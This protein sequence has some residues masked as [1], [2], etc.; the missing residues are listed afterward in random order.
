MMDS[1]LLE[2]PTASAV[3]VAPFHRI[4]ATMWEMK[5]NGLGKAFQAVTRLAGLCVC[6]KCHCEDGEA[7]RVESDASTSK[8]DGMMGPKFNK[9]RRRAGTTGAIFGPT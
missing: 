1:G 8:A 7:R 4:P 9:R 2:P 6:R 5:K 3:G